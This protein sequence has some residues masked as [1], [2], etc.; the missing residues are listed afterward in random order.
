MGR[1]LNLSRKFHKNYVLNKHIN[2]KIN[3]HENHFS[4]LQKQYITHWT[5]SKLKFSIIALMLSYISLLIW[6]I[7]IQLKYNFVIFY[8]LQNNF[9]NSSRKFLEENSGFNV[10]GSDFCFFLV[11]IFDSM[12]CVWTF[13]ISM[14][15]N[16]YIISIFG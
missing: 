3:R 2:R 12:Y 4:A 6:E 13:C 5:D 1:E 16:Q 8:Q 14:F 15:F 9:L 10:S 11:L 7:N